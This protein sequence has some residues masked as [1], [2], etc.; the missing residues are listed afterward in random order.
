MTLPV[1]VYHKKMQEYV[2]YAKKET[3]DSVSI[4]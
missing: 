3:L 1:C 2:G 4:Q